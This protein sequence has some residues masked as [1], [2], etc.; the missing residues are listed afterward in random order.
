[1]TS[2][3]QTC[4]AGVSIMPVALLALCPKGRDRTPGLLPHLQQVPLQS[5]FRLYH[6]VDIN[7]AEE[8][9]SAVAT[10]DPKPAPSA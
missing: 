9:A 1:M 8:W 4:S 7:Q 6:C 10:R 3:E 5:M 2:A